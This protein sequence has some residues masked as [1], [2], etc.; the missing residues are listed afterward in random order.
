MPTRQQQLDA[1]RTIIAERKET[2]RRFRETLQSIPPDDAT[3]STFCVIRN[4]A[5]SLIEA[6]EAR[7]D[8]L[9]EYLECTTPSAGQDLAQ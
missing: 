1:L 4:I 2:A 7:D 3:R 9:L 6:D 5:L 8:S